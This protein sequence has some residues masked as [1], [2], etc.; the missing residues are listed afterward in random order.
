M[1]YEILEKLFDIWMEKNHP[2]H[3]TILSL[4]YLVLGIAFLASIICV[5][6][7]AWW[8]KVAL[9]VIVTAICTRILA[10]AII[11]VYIQQFKYEKI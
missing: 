7:F 6:F 8:W 11:N 1:D 9:L 10:R 2:H 3:Y 4:I 5:F